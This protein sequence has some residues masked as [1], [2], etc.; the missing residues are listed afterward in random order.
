MVSLNQNTEII[1]D[2][3]LQGSNLLMSLILPALFPWLNNNYKGLFPYQC[4]LPLNKYG[5][6]LRKLTALWK[7]HLEKSYT[8]TFRSK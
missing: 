4:L 5:L 3:I 6:T 1:Y 7:C 8:S 2:I